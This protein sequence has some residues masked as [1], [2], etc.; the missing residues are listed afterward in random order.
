[1]NSILSFI[2]KILKSIIIYLE[3][4]LGLKRLED[5]SNYNEG[6][7]N[8]MNLTEKCI[9]IS[10]HQTDFNAAACKLAGVTTVMCRLAYGSSEDTK[11]RAY[12]GGVL[13]GGMRAGG[14]GFATWHYA[15]KAASFAV[16]KEVMKLQVTKWIELAK[17]CGCTS[18]VAIDQELENKQTMALSKSDNT[19][20]LCEAAQMIENAG[21]S[22]CLYASASWIMAHVDL[23]QFHWPLW[24]A[25]YKWSGNND[26]DNL[27]DN[28]VPN[29]GQYGTWMNSNKDKIC[30]WQFTSQGF[31]D[32]YGCVHGSNNVD[33]NFLYFQPENWSLY[34]EA[35]S[36]NQPMKEFY[37][38]YIGDTV[39]IATALA[40]IGEENSYD[41][42]KT[43][44]AA[45]NIVDYTGTPKQN[46]YMLS[47]LKA[48]KLIKPTK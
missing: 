40:S 30:M 15:S 27:L 22:P 8:I 7:E 45:N 37:P 26:F 12:F 46:T 14:Y 19:E 35:L 20:L 23:N 38:K 42:R 31:A 32:K 3:D 18:W 34:K 10:K 33:K 47:L 24:V 39:S 4:S 48:G 21:L 44:A 25:Y 17:A 6:D 9:D 43:I 28:F 41:Y 11:A 5:Q 29:S 36:S 16:A 1:M 2:K 13:S